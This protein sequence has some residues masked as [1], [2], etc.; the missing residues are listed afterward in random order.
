M[1][2]I[3]L[4]HPAFDEI[5][6]KMKNPA[7]HGGLAKCDYQTHVTNGETIA[8][9]FFDLIVYREIEAPE[10]RRIDHV[11][12]WIEAHKED[13]FSFIG[14][15]KAVPGRRATLY[16]ILYRLRALGFIER[17][18]KQFATKLWWATNKWRQTSVQQVKAAY[19]NYMIVRRNTTGELR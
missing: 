13:Q 12:A 19:D 10:P 3:V 5:V 18:D 6:Y 11:I 2:K 4:S 16:T 1:I 9:Q 15:L 17:T 14:L 8:L 7:A